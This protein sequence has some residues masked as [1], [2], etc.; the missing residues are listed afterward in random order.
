L[1]SFQDLRLNDRITRALAEEKYLLPTPIQVQTIPIVMS[2]VGD[3]VA[4]GYAQSL[5]QPGGNLT[6]QPILSPDALSKRLQMLPET[7]PDPCS[8]AVLA[9]VVGLVIALAIPGPKSSR[10][11]IYLTFAGATGAQY[12]YQ[13]GASAR[14]LC[15]SATTPGSYAAQ[16]GP[17]LIAECR[18][19][20]LPT[21]R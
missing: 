20:G 21:G 1:T 13:C 11:C 7:V 15:R 8:V 17:G 19:A 6:G 4:L 18:K 14:V 9:L 16:A 5:A 3:A 12:V 2:I 10:G